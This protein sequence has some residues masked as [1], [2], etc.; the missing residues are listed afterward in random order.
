V[1]NWSDA[2]DLQRPQHH[3]VVGHHQHAQARAV[4]SCWTSTSTCRPVEA[5]KVTPVRS[6]TSVA[7]AA[8]T[9]S[10][11]AARSWFS[12]AHVHLVGHVDDGDGAD[13]LQAD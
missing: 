12:V 1:T 7:G 4:A 3:P 10:V 8:D 2:G 9:A 6:S 13:V 5:K 11:R